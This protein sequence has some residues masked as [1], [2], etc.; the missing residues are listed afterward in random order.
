MIRTKRV[1]EA[2]EDG[3]GRRFFVERLW[4]RGMKKESLI[5]EAWLREVAPSDTLRRWFHHDP[6]KWEEFQRRY[7]AELDTKPETWQLLL[8]AAGQGHLT[9]LFSA[10]DLKRN[11]A[12]LL[13]NYLKK[14]LELT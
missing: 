14:K 3:D 4:P 10:R 8:K 2:A 9:L 7:R 5:M 6:E 11:S 13:K 12:V 1:Y